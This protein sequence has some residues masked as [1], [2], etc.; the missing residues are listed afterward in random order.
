MLQRRVFLQTFIA[1][2]LL[3]GLTMAAD[4]DKS[5]Q[6]LARPLLPHENE[7]S[8]LEVKAAF[9]DAVRAASKSTVRVLSSGT[10]VAFGAIVHRDGYVVTKA[11]ELEGR[12]QCQL[13]DGRKFAASIVGIQRDFDIALLKL[14]A[15]ELPVAKW[16]SASAPPVGSWLATTGLSELPTAIGVASATAGPL[17][18]PQ[19]ILG[20]GLEQVG[21][22]TRVNRVFPGS[23]ASKAGLRIGDVISQVNG[24]ALQRPKQISGAIRKLLPGER[25]TLLIDRGGDSLSIP[26]ILGD[27]T[28]LGNEEQA[29][30]M[31]SLGGPLSERRVGF[32]FVLQHDTILRPQ[33]CGGPLVDLDGKVIGI[34]IARVSRVASYA[35]PTSQLRPVLADLMAGK[36]PPP[37]ERVA[38]EA[39]SAGD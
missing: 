25:V 14:P 27:A 31:E 7:R 24:Q 29:K 36:Y 26:A 11:S 38:L 28:R 5:R 16:S 4:E 33:E 35:V 1:T 2:C 6:W 20:V 23:A 18:K 8:Q 32:P 17:P 9:R 19:A 3:A 39:V 13:A 22:Q 12:L 34:N 10:Q 30:L 21:A 15:K 37:A